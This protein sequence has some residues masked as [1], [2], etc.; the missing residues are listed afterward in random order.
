M[1]IALGGV[2]LV[3]LVPLVVEGAKELGMPDRAARWLALILS[4]VGALTAQLVK[5]YPYIEPW[6]TAVVGGLMVFFTA[7]GIYRVAKGLGKS[8][9]GNLLVD[10]EEKDGL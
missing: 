5:E 9:S 7:T 10:V 1:E 4:I 3:V 2:L 6:V 8:L